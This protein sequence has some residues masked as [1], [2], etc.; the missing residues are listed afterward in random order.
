MT[1]T[2]EVHWNGKLYL[3]I[4]CSFP[5]KREKNE[6]IEVKEKVMDLLSFNHNFQNGFRLTQ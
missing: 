6:H 1:W 3:N 5:K 4:V 2:F